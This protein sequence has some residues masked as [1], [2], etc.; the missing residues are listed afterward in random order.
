MDLPLVQTLFMYVVQK[1]KKI[2][3][4][5]IK[6]CTPFLISLFYFSSALI[7]LGFC[8][9]QAH[10]FLFLTNPTMTLTSF[11]LNNMFILQK[12]LRPICFLLRQALLVFHDLRYC[13]IS[14]THTHT[15]ESKY[16]FIKYIISASCLWLSIFAKKKKKRIS[17]RV[18][19]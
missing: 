13:T 11:W 12:S 3:F 15:C 6:L 18:S 8:S 4:T 7:F 17:V 2:K 14:H 10:T 16:I 1:I 19:V 9:S 5:F